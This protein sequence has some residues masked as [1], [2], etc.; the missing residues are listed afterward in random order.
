MAETKAILKAVSTVDSKLSTLPIED[1]QLIFVYDKKKIALDNRGTRTVYEQIQTIEKEA[2]REELLAPIDSFYF[3]I[4]TS[5]LWRYANGK[6][7]QITSQPAEKV[8][9]ED[10]YLNFPSVG[11]E[12]QIYIDRSENAT[13]RWD[14]KSLKYYCVGRDYMNIKIIDGCF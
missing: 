6:W 7:I 1:G 4:E 8:I 14:D 9:T 11:S 13:Y 3:V 12:N 2:Q 5:I 10:S